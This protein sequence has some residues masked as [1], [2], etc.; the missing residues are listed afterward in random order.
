LRWKTISGYLVGSVA[1]L[2]LESHR[3]GKVQ[4]P[5]D[6]DALYIRRS[7]AELNWRL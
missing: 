7:D 1:R 2:A 5:A 4:S 3:R 6:L